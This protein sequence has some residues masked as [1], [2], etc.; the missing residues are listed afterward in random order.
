[1]ARECARNVER[2][3]ADKSTDIQVQG[4]FAATRRS[5]LLF[6]RATQT[7]LWALPLINRLGMKYGSEKLFGS[8]YNVPPV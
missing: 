6:Q 4:Q 7:Y 3:P 5:V 8:G 2:N 1:M